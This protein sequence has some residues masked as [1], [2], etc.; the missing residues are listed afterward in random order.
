VVGAARSGDP[1]GHLRA[2]HRPPLY[3]EGVRPTPLPLQG[4]G[5]RDADRYSAL[6]APPLR[7]TARRA[8]PARAPA[9]VT[10]RRDCSP[11]QD[12]LL[13]AP[14]QGRPGV[15]LQ[16]A[17]V[18]LE[19]RVVKAAILCAPFSATPASEHAD[20]RCA[21]GERRREGLSSASACR[22]NECSSVRWTRA[23]EVVMAEVELRK[24][25]WVAIR[26]HPSPGARSE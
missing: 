23:A 4:K 9:A 13:D 3:A 7:V 10:S 25:R 21:G 15:S 5:D 12:H 17:L 14:P 6:S 8:P 18:V 1:R 26:R 16:P 22:L 20:T 2:D 11:R 19:P 24:T